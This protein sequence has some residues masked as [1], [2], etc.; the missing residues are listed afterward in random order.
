[1]ATMEEVHGLPRLRTA[2]DCPTCDPR[3]TMC[4]RILAIDD[5]PET[6]GGLKRL[7]GAH[8]YEVREENDSTKALAS[9][10][11]FQPHYVILDYWMPHAHGGD[12]AWQIASERSLGATK[13]VMCSGFDPETFRRALPPLRIPIFEKPVDTDALLELIRAY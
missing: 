1:M 10:K 3:S 6:T 9:A 5:D 2:T 11:E 12:V 8:G 7:L 13:L 4:R